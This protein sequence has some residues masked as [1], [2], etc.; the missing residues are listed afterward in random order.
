MSFIL[1]V[2]ILLSEEDCQVLQEKSFRNTFDYAAM[3][4][5]GTQEIKL[6]NPSETVVI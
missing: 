3:Q 2:N 5:K 6:E 1:L 4:C